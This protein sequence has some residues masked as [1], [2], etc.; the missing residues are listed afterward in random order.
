MRFR[1]IAK[2]TIIFV[3]PVRPSIRPHGTTGLPME[4]ILYLRIF[5]KSIEKIQLLRNLRR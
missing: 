4:E 3:M 2:T 5:K 1:K